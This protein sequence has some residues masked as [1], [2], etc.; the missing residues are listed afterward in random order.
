HTMFSRDWSSDVCS[1]D[2]LVVVEQRDGDQQY[3]QHHDRQRR[4]H[5]PV[6]VVEELLPQHLADHQ[7]F[8]T[9]E[10]FGHDELADHGNE[11]QHGAGNDAGTRQRY[12]HL[13]ERLDAPGAEILR[14]FQLISVSG[15]PRSSGTMNSPTTGMN[16]SVEPATMPA[17]DSGT[18][19]F[20]NALMRPAPR[21][22]AASSRVGSCLTRLAY[23]GS[24]M[25]GR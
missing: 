17:R 5:R 22:C 24:T 10:Q 2:L 14:R 6:A 15:P 12:C 19:T 13:P 21:S 7:G 8:R 3:G 9:A 18:V 16:T 25:K 20:Q 23:S 11:Y 4:G 1:S